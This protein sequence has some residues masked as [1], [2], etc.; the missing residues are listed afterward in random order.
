M[1]SS[2][3]SFYTA[4]EISGIQTPELYNGTSP[5][6]IPDNHSSLNGLN[7]KLGKVFLSSNIA[8]ELSKKDFPYFGSTQKDTAAISFLLF[9]REIMINSPDIGNYT[10]AD[11]PLYTLNKY[12][13]EMRACLNIF[14]SLY[15]DLINLK[16][17][18]EKAIKG[19]V[20]KYCFEKSQSGSLKIC[21][22][23]ESYWAEYEQF[24][25]D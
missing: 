14:Q 3:D 15:P 24:A 19:F 5:A 9:A 16:H 20:H 4:K 1:E 11:S 7:E 25:T 13:Q 8:L 12:Y 23:F 22:P 6:E 21:M 2:I 18:S 10:K 17:M